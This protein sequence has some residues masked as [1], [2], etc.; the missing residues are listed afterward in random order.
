[1]SALTTG[2][3]GPSLVWI[4]VDDDID[5]QLDRSV[6][7]A[8]AQCIDSLPFRISDIYSLSR[9]ESEPHDGLV[10]SL[11][12]SNDIEAH[13]HIGA[14]ADWV[15]GL[16]R[17]GISTQF[18][19]SVLLNNNNLDESLGL[20]AGSHQ[21][22]SKRKMDIEEEEGDGGQAPAKGQR[23]DGIFMQSLSSLQQ[24]SG[25]G[26]GPSASAASASAVGAGAAV[27]A[28]GQSD[29]TNSTHSGAAS[30]I[31][32]LPSLLRSPN[33]Q[34]QQRGDSDGIIVSLLKALTS[35]GAPSSLAQSGLGATN[36]N[37][38]AA[39]NAIASQH[40][41][42][43]HGSR[44]PSSQP[45]EQLDLIHNQLQSLLSGNGCIQN[46]SLLGHSTACAP[47]PSPSPLAPSGISDQLSM[48]GGSLA[49]LEDRNLEA[50]ILGA[51][52]LISNPVIAAQVLLRSGAYPQFQGML[53][54]GFDT[55]REDNFV[56][57][58]RFLPEQR[59]Q[60]EQA[61]AGA[62]PLSA[63]MDASVGNSGSSSHSGTPSSNLKHSLN[64][65]PAS[66]QQ[67]GQPQDP[68]TSRPPIL[69]YT[70][71]DDTSLSRYQCLVRQQIEMFEATEDD[72]QFNISRMSKIIVRGQVG[73]RCR[74]CAV[75]PQYSRPKAAV[76]YPRTL[77][78]MYQ[79][80][81]NMVKN[82]LC[83]CCE[84]IPSET[85]D[86]L[87]AL[88]EARKRG[89]G[90]RDRWAQAAREMGVIEDENGLRF[91]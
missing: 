64:G 63:S 8:I 81:Q 38:P 21:G 59:S 40:Q 52:M 75:L 5:G 61:G 45:G 30:Q 76:Y 4:L 51:Q 14:P 69:L 87:M 23:M 54:Q 24:G 44:E 37:I 70:Q 39:V 82:H 89:R 29:A 80:G 48:I 83:A 88:Q 67:G 90:G 43:G 50:A 73:I 35:S 28:R 72:V 17:D 6:L 65:A 3:I 16:A 32:T 84:L 25:T 10:E 2:Q 27:S 91:K 15:Y 26:I 7:A 46:S 47:A 31:Y 79:F 55:T 34:Q 68:R 57:S 58:Q 19:A 18:L 74:H 20:A 22:G 49:G 62:Q 56:A 71:S 33:D 41:S 86:L 12:K 60:V 77:D 13:V 9:P 53:Q 1:M 36:S 42:L 66:L 11:S 85:K 78:S